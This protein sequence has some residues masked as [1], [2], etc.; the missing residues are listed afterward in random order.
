MKYIHLMYTTLPKDWKKRRKN[1][2]LMNN[3][4]LEEMDFSHDIQSICAALT[5]VWPACNCSAPRLQQTSPLSALTAGLLL[6]VCVCGILNAVCVN[7]KPL[8]CVCIRD[9]QLPGE[10][11]SEWCCRSW[12]LQG[13]KYYP[14]PLFF[15]LKSEWKHTSWKGEATPALQQILDHWVSAGCLQERRPPVCVS[16]W[17]QR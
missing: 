7:A 13:V 5:L 6:R 12:I 11:S 16:H 8:G 3:L 9:R 2:S 10:L 17:V 1:P 4:G 14:P 15:F